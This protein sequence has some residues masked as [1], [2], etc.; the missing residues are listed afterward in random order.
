MRSLYSDVKLVRFGVREVSDYINEQGWRGFKLNGKKILI[1]GGGWT[2]DLL[3]DNRPKKVAAEVA[4][5][6]HMNLNALRR[7]GILGLESKSS[8]TSATRTAS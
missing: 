1:R 7:R 2:D 8:T 5:A 3:L 4:Y 6:R